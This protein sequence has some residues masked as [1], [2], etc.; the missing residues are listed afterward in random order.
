[1]EKI[2]SAKYSILPYDM[3]QY[4]NRTSGVLLESIYVGTIPIAPRSLLEHNKLPGIKYDSL[5]E[6]LNYKW[7][8]NDIFLNRF[9]EIYK[10]NSIELFRNGFYEMMKKM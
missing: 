3:N 7:D 9:H 4:I 1:M 10:K 6:L 5:N 2:S 8:D